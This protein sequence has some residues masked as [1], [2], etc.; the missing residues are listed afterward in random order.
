[1]GRKRKTKRQPNRIVNKLDI[2][3]TPIP[4][5]NWVDIRRFRQCEKKKAYETEK[6]ASETGMIVYQCEFCR[7]WHRTG[8][9]GR[10]AKSIEM[11]LEKRE[12]WAQKRKH[13]INGQRGRWAT[14]TY[15]SRHSER[16]RNRLNMA[17][18]DKARRIPDAVL[19]TLSICEIKGP[20]ADGFHELHLP[21]GHLERKHYQAVDE[22]LK[23]LGGKWNKKAKAHLFSDD[24]REIVE[25][26]I[27][28]GEYVR[29]GDMGWFPTPE[30]IV[31]EMMCEADFPLR[32]GMRVLEPSAGE[33]AI[34][35]Q[36]LEAGCRLD[37]YEL[38]VK[39]SLKLLHNLTT[40]ELPSHAD[41][42]FMVHQTDFLTVTPPAGP[43]GLY[44]RILMNPP[45]APAQAD[46]DHVTHALK[47]LAPGGRLVAIMSA[48]TEFRENRKAVEFRELVSTAPYSHVIHGLPDGAFKASG[49]NVRTVMVVVDRE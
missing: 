12:V 23:A 14:R 36:L 28:T 9:I 20:R 44:P 1:M 2:P 24:P 16:N 7:K 41:R 18:K 32:S 4:I 26:A 30:D 49:T 6:E 17:V 8:I 10:A 5:P 21:A 46:I 15:Y 3:I 25:G 33:G 29:P 48:G 39:R 40:C 11:L 27:A 43:E 22:V 34:A 42:I 45:F 31:G 19:G 38:D 47:F 35:V 37:C 13:K